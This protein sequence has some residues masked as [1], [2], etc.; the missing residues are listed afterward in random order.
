[1]KRQ[2]SRE[3]GADKK[4]LVKSILKMVSLI[5]AICSYSYM[6]FVV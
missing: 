5:A 1:M 3:M 4:F 6:P 2:E